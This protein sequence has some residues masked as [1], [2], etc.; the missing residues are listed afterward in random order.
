VA[1]SLND[2]VNAGEGVQ[3]A[4]DHGNG[5]FGSKGVANAYLVCTDDGDVQINTGLASDAPEIR[6]CFSEVSPGPLR[7]IILTQGHPDHVGGWSYFAGPGVET[8]AQA[9]HGE[10]REYWRS[11]RPF[12]SRR[13]ARLWSQFRPSTPENAYPREAELTTAFADRHSFELGGRRFELYATP[14]GETL[15]SLIVWLPGDRTV[16]IGNLMGPMFGHVP[17]LYTI[18]GDKIPSAISFIHGIDR[19][20]QLEPEVLINGHGKFTGAGQIRETLELVRAAT[21]YMRDQ[22]IEGMN[23]GKT[24]WELMDEVTMPAHLAVPQ[25]HGKAAWI[26]RAVY[27]EHTGWFRYESTTELYS[28]PPSSVWADLVELAGAGRLCDRARA[29]VESGRPLEAIHLVEPVLSADPHDPAASR[30]MREALDQLLERSG[31]E[32][33]SEVQWLK[34]EIAALESGGN[35]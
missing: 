25:L 11:L 4:D 16:F 20:L 5:I 35:R 10:V 34:Q 6:R 14:G 24:L 7:V 22:T 8:I 28:V 30:V 18:R 13:I 19:V 29:H 12:S 26:V 2:L 17:N 3:P 1:Q 27:E 15:D 33:F 31:E 23:A 32:N 21:A 9:N